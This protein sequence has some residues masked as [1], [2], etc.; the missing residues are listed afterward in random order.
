M[1]VTSIRLQ[2]DVESGLEA[3]TE[4]LQRSR[5]WVINEAVR[6]YI[7]KQSLE[8]ERW[9]QTRSAIES[10]AAGHV[11]DGEAVHRWMRSWGTP[12]ELPPPKPGA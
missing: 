5:N 12:G 2:P 9:E 8:S 7:A 10:V 6:E 4:T 3:I 11:L 1:S